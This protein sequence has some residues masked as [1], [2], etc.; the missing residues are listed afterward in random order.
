MINFYS[1]NA[2]GQNLALF[3]NCCK[4]QKSVILGYLSK[5]DCL[6]AAQWPTSSELKINFDPSLDRSWCEFFKILKD[7]GPRNPFLGCNF[8]VLFPSRSGHFFKIKN[9]LSVLSIYTYSGLWLTDLSKSGE[10]GM[11][12]PGPPSSNS[13]TLTNVENREN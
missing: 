6:W 5:N 9:Q 3:W 4:R 11:V 8:G 7:Q 1:I 2:L 13:P 12:F 10:G